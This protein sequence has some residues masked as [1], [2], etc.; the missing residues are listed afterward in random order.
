MCGVY[1]VCYLC[2]RKANM[3]VRQG[4]A[5]LILSDVLAI[6]RS[7]MTIAHKKQKMSYL[8]DQAMAI[9]R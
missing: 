7:F 2:V 1:S 8:H 6:L 9:M 5:S 3:Y 4:R